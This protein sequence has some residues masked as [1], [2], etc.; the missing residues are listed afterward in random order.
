[1]SH[2]HLFHGCIPAMVTPFKDGSIDLLALDNLTEHLISGGV[3]ALCLLGT[4]GESVTL[5]PEERSTIV[6]HVVDRVGG[7]TP[8]LLGAGTNNTRETVELIKGGAD[9]GVDGVMVVT[10]YYNKPQESFYIKHYEEAADAAQSAGVPVVMYNIPSRTGVDMTTSSILHLAQHPNIIGIK[11]GADSLEKLATIIQQTP[12]NF[13]LYS[14]SDSI[15]LPILALGAAGVITVLGNIVPQ[16]VVDICQH[17]LRGELDDAKAHYYD[18]LE[19]SKLIFRESS[20]APTKLALELMGI[21]QG[22]LRP[23]LYNASSET[24]KLLR[25]ELERLGVIGKA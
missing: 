21:T 8:I 23:P 2:K 15:N 14:A 7:R 18:T 13:A 24:G 22:E 4:T 25:S 11:E 12:D 5:T 19:L 9:L 16:R 20:P 6:K 10:P 3:N 17:I 1:M